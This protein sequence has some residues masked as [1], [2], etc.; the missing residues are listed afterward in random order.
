MRK[1]VRFLLC[2]VLC[3]SLSQQVCAAELPLVIDGAGLLTE[4]EESSLET[5]A[6]TLAELYQMD[7]VILT[8]D[9]LSG[10]PAYRYAD[11][12]YDQN[13][14][15]NDGILF[16][17]S[18]QEREWYISTCGKAI[19]ALSGHEMDLLSEEIIPYLSGGMYYDAFSQY[20]ASLPGYMNMDPGNH[21]EPEYPEYQTQN[22]FGEQRTAPNLFISL[23]I[24][25]AAA[26]VVVLVMWASMNTKRRQR[27]AGDYL[28][29]G[30]F[31]LRTHRDVFL[32]SNISKTRRQENNS[33]S[34]GH[35][36]S[37]VHRSTGGRSHGGRGG[38][39]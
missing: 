38:K 35:H 11:D 34:G 14:Y 23:L 17:L 19:S 16:L 2:L 12:Y 25:V 36:G 5:A 32:Y 22:D 39:F 18:M 28:K 15:A 31:H 10:S 21:P 13:G 1:T 9:T 6:R 20:L 3:F 7:I 37:S 4:T 27:S 8:V 26:A 24:G 33:H 29:P 30:T